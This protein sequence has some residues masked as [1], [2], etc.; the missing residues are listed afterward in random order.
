VPLNFDSD[1]EGAV[2]EFLAAKQLNDGSMQQA[3]SRVNYRGQASPGAHDPRDPFFPSMI[4]RGH[5]ERCL[6]QGR[7]AQQVRGTLQRTFAVLLRHDLIAPAVADDAPNT[8][9]RMITALGLE[10]VTEG[11]HQMFIEGPASVVR[12]RR[13]ATAL[14]HVPGH[15]GAGSGF[16]WRPDLLVTAAHVIDGLAQHGTIHVQFDGEQDSLAAQGLTVADP[17][18]DM[19]LDIGLVHLP[20]Q[21]R[22]RLAPSA[23]GVNLLE[24]VVVLGFPPI[25]N[26]HPTMV[27][28]RA[29]IAA[30]AQS[31][32]NR[33][34]NLVLSSL[35]RGGNSGGPVLDR[36]GRVVGIISEN[37]FPSLAEHERDLI[38]G[39]G[40]STAVSAQWLEL[41]RA[42]RV[43]THSI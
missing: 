25:P 31:Y 42:G 27:A 38:Q 28:H 19:H 4:T 40:Y 20:A 34:E 2:L 11:S 16:L 17:V 14:L 33:P 3:W 26:A 6:A 24:E 23:N 1:P 29:E 30:I 41:L 22:Q 12:S 5:L 7:S 36:R 10:L 21:Q 32:H 35:V 13:A 39:L 37:L 15:E 18:D 43:T 9:F 8:E